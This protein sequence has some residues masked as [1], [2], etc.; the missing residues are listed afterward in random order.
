MPIRVV[1]PSYHPHEIS[2]WQFD[3]K[4]AHLSP[5]GGHFEG[6][7]QEKQIPIL[8]FHRS[9][10][11]SWCNEWSS[12]YLLHVL[13]GQFFG[14]HIWATCATSSE[15]DKKI[16]CGHFGDCLVFA[17][18]LHPLSI[19]TK[20]DEIDSQSLVLSK[21][22]DSYPWHLTDFVLYCDVIKCSHN[23]LSSLEL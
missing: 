18:P 14:L 2:F 15:R 9:L 16:D 17:F 7:L 10:Q 11:L 1:G 6:F 22:T 23:F 4:H 5:F 20:T 8:P 19:C 13:N 21:W 12:W 3:Q